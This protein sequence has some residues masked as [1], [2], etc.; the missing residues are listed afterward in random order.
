MRTIASEELQ[1]PGPRNNIWVG[2]IDDPDYG[3]FIAPDNLYTIKVEAVDPTGVLPT[4][5][6]EIDVFVE[7]RWN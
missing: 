6:E 5:R 3:I 2:E 7:S 4:V 1:Q